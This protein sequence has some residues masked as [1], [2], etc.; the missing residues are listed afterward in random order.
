MAPRSDGR[1][2]SVVFRVPLSRPLHIV[3]IVDS[4]LTHVPFLTLRHAFERVTDECPIVIAQVLRF[5]QPETRPIF[6]CMLRATASDEMRQLP[7]PLEYRRLFELDE[8]GLDSHT[9][10]EDQL[11]FAEHQISRMGL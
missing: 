11:S 4:G 6:D 7:R 10:C 9:I 5:P 1:S 2:E 8:V 3:W